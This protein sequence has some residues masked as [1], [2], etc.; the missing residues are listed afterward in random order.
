M[1][2]AAAAAAAAA[3]HTHTRGMV[4]R[5]LMPENFQV[6]GRGGG[7][8]ATAA[9]TVATLG[10]FFLRDLA[11]PPAATDLG[12][13]RVDSPFFFGAFFPVPG[14]AAVVDAAALLTRGDWAGAILFGGLFFVEFVFLF[15]VVFFF[16]SAASASRRV[17]SPRRAALPAVGLLLLLLRSLVAGLSSRVRPPLW[18]P[19]EFAVATTD[20][21]RPL[22]VGGNSPPSRRPSPPVGMLRWPAP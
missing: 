7:S 8:T 6:G 11:A 12:F 14:A 1:L 19:S 16:S 17:A 4:K 2:A 20:A 18:P 9:P 22:K 15:V 13:A 3:T 10:F 5:N 21:T